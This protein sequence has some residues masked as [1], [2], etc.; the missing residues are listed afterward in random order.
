MLQNLKIDKLNYFLF[1]IF[2][3]LVPVAI[4]QSLL[5]ALYIRQILAQGLVPQAYRFLGVNSYLSP[6]VKFALLVIGL[7]L[8]YSIGKQNWQRVVQASANKKPKRK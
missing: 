5:E 7:I 4:F 3:T 8:G 2:L 6:L 1:F